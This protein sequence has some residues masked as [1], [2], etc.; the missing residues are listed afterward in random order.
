MMS[1]AQSITPTISNEPSG[2]PM[3]SNAAETLARIQQAVTRRDRITHRVKHLLSAESDVGSGGLPDEKKDLQIIQFPQFR[4]VEGRPTES[5][6]ALQEWEGL[7]IE[8]RD[9]VVI[10][11]L[12]DIAST[13]VGREERAEIPIAEVP[14]EDRHRA[15]P[16]ALFRWVI[17]FNRKSS[18]RLSR[19]SLIY[20]RRTP[21]HFSSI[22]PALEFATEDD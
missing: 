20:F 15:V 19:S 9:G 14:Q 3:L 16:G 10:A 2:G 22:G 1:A 13:H 5:L 4:P 7:V 11:E 18:G 8:V 17:G 6:A 21:K 12:A